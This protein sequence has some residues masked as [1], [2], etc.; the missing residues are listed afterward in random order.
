MISSGLCGRAG[1][2]LFFFPTMFIR[3]TG[4]Q[5]SQCVYGKAGRGGFRLVEVGRC[6]LYSLFPF[7]AFPSISLISLVSF[8]CAAHLYPPALRGGRLL[9]FD[10]FLFSASRFARCFS[11]HFLFSNL[12]IIHPPSIIIIIIIITINDFILSSST[13]SSSYLSAKIS[14]SDVETD[15]EMNKTKL[16][17]SCAQVRGPGKGR[18]L[19]GFYPRA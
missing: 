12:S 17:V 11:H 3:Q 6:P 4:Y 14:W 18:G 9:G 7:L 10:I 13:L 19:V 1:T 5:V 16:G 15:E 2:C 8:P